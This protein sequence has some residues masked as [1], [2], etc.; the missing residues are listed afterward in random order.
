MKLL[1][2][3]DRIVRPVAIPNLT[4]ILVIGQVATFLLTLLEP[5]FTERLNLVW[6]RVYEGE[7]WRL[8]TFVFFPPAW[9]IFVIFY[10]YI[11]MFLGKTL[12]GYWGTVRFNTY[13]YVGTLMTLLAGLIVPS[14]PFTG[15]YFQSTVFLAFAT[16]NPNYEFLIM[17]VLPVK[18]KWLA[19]LQFITFFLMLSSGVPAI[20]LMVVASL[21]NYFLFFGA[22][23]FRSLVR[24]RTRAKWAA[25][26]MQ[27]NKSVK[28]A[29]HKCSVCGID[30]Q[31]HP[32]ED[33][34]YCSKCEGQHAYCEAHLRNHVH[35][36]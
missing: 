28:V 18:V 29:R 6:D 25:S 21:A 16:L 27:Q 4:E 31:S 24:I 20:Q 35:K 32:N 7:V 34:R 17:L 8:I 5:G 19:L 22:D 26:Q 33:F 9:G 3:L 36:T 11:F 1:E 2:K 13:F 12:E 30:S 14:E 10:F 23:L 15:L